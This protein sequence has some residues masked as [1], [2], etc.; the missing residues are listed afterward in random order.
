MYEILLNEE[1]LKFYK[2]SDAFTCTI[3]IES[4]TLNNFYNYKV[5]QT[6]TI[7]ILMDSF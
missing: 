1:L 5:H 2:L 3:L 6:K 4:V 7:G